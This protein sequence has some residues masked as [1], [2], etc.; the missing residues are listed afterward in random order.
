[1][2]VGVIYSTSIGALFTLFIGWH[3]AAACFPWRHK[4]YATLQKV[5]GQTIIIPRQNG[6]SDVSVGAGL[7]IALLVAGN[8]AACAIR[9]HTTADL[10]KRT[11]RIS[12][13]NLVPLFL[14]G[15]TSLVASRLCGLSLPRHGLLHRW[16]GRIFV[17]EAIVHAVSSL[18]VNGWS[19][20]ILHVV[21]RTWY[22]G[23]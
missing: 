5:I 9:V 17:S 22:D 18:A 6:T 20:S 19:F 4:A 15:R 12:A 23:H 11:G 14:G 8:A 13:I 10:A 21:V 16:L 3:L 7:C 2:D 1:M